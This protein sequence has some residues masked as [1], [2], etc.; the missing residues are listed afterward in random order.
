MVEVPIEQVVA[1]K[2]TEEGW[3]DYDVYLA[4][5]WKDKDLTNQEAV[6]HAYR[7]GLVWEIER[8]IRVAAGEHIGPVGVQGH[9]GTQG[10]Q[11]SNGPWGPQGSQGVQGLQSWGVQGV[12]GVTGTQG[13][14]GSYEPVGHW[15]P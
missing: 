9:Q 2:M 7:I 13:V 1:S 6:D 11:R 15:M 4:D 14:Q 3:M 5:N 10:P 12:Q 8:T